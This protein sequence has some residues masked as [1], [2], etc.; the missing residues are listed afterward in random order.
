MEIIFLTGRR[1]GTNTKRPRIV[2]NEG[3]K[4]RY[5]TVTADVIQQPDSTY[6]LTVS[7][8]WLRLDEAGNRLAE[9]AEFTIT[10]VSDED[11]NIN[12]VYTPYGYFD[13]ELPESLKS[14]E[15]ANCRIKTRKEFEEDNFEKSITIEVD[16]S[17]KSRFTI[18]L[19][20]RITGVKAVTK[21]TEN[22]NQKKPGSH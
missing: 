8:G 12:L 9:G 13:L 17:L 3:K 2:T 15:T 5:V 16:N 10:N 19:T 22:S 21:K 14:G 7:P 18:P 20:Q 11:L 6:P 1:K 4:S